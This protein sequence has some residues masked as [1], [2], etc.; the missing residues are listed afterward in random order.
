MAEKSP[1]KV[2]ETFSKA[3]RTKHGITKA[4]FAERIGWHPSALYRLEK[5]GLDFTGDHLRALISVGWL[6]EGNEWWKLFNEAIER[7]AK[8]PREE[9]ARSAHDPRNS[10]VD[11]TELVQKPRKPN[12]GLLIAAAVAVIGMTVIGCMLLSQMTGLLGDKGGASPSAVT[13]DQTVV[14]LAAQTLVCRSVEE[15]VPAMS[16]SGGNASRKEA[17][18]PLPTNSPYPTYTPAPTYTILPV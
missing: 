14:A 3:M 10:G 9:R 18:E 7:A 6:K 5:G 1:T 15:T 11:S 17:S 8:A 13:A 2:L 16:A 12:K 4:A